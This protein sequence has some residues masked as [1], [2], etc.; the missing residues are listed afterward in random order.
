MRTLKTILVV[1]MAMIAGACATV[2]PV[3]VAV[4]TSVP[5]MVETDGLRAALRVVPRSEVDRVF[6]D[7]AA[8][9]LG[10]VELIVVNHKALPVVVERKSIRF[11]APDGQDIYPV[12]PVGVANLTS[13]GGAMIST[14]SNA[15][16]AVQLLF[17]LARLAQ[18]HEIAAKWDH[19]MPERFEVPAG[20]DRRMWLAFSTPHW[21]P[22]IWRLE[23]PFDADTSAAGPHLSIPLTFKAAARAPANGKD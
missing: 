11:V 21:A 17:G 3:P 12:S 5:A 20:K 15:L 7:G 6:G 19:L 4:D 16:D 13:R 2:A 9:Q 23:L 14:G 8:T 18:N 22:G 1:S 10:V